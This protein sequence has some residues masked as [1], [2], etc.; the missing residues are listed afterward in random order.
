MKHRYLLFALGT[1][2][3][4]ANG[5]WAQAPALGHHP[6]AGSG[7]K[8]CARECVPTTK[9]VYSSVCKEY[10]VP[11]FSLVAWFRRCCGDN[12]AC[13]E[14]GEVHFKRV[15]VKKIDP[16]TQTTACVLKDA[17][18]PAPLTGTVPKQ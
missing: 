7:L 9:T 16:G 15:L 14:C 3:L 8:F 5:S 12:S 6:D 2:L 17:A 10:C 13:S 1:M 18:G 11:S 4:A